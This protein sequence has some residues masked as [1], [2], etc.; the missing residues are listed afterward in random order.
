MEL[1]EKPCLGICKLFQT[2]ALLSEKKK[3]CNVLVSLADLIFLSSECG[4]LDFI[5]F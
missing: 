5:Y 1:G 4:Q 2:R 3:I